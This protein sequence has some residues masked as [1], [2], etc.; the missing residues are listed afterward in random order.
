MKLLSSKSIRLTNTASCC[1][2]RV[3]ITQRVIGSYRTHIFIRRESGSAFLL[4]RSSVYLAWMFSCRWFIPKS[5]WRLRGNMPSDF[6]ATTGERQF[7]FVPHNRKVSQVSIDI[8]SERLIYLAEATKIVAK[9]GKKPPHRSCIF[10]WASH[11]SKGI[12]LETL[13]GPGGKMTSAEALQRFF[14]RLTAA[15]SGQ[16]PPIATSATRKRAIREAREVLEK[17]GI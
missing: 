14:E 3:L 13:Q 6:L 17:A 12:V 1:S 7:R 5:Y 8:R 16:S 2:L 9:R 15:A 11:G 10:R 4:L